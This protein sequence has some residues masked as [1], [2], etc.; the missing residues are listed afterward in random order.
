MVLNGSQASVF[1]LRFMY[2]FE[3]SGGGKERGRKH[4]SRGVDG[5]KERISSRLPTQHRALHGPLSHDSVIWPEPKSR[6]GHITYWATQAPLVS[7]SFKHAFPMSSCPHC[8]APGLTHCEN[9]RVFIKLNNKRRNECIF[10][11]GIQVTEA[12]CL[13]LIHI[14]PGNFI[15]KYN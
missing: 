14:I 10:C 11:F 9:W 5:Q 4:E 12:S 2:L 7:P 1:F 6:V 15:S 13:P 3:R 8:L